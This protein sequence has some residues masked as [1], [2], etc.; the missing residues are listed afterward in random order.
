MVPQVPKEG[1]ICGPCDRPAY[2]KLYKAKNIKENENGQVNVEGNSPLRK[3]SNWHVLYGPG[4]RQA[5]K[6]YRGESCTSHHTTHQVSGTCIIPRHKDLLAP[7]QPST[8]QGVRR[9]HI[10]CLNYR[11][12]WEQPGQLLCLGLSRVPPGGGPV[13]HVHH[14]LPL[15]QVGGDAVVEVLRHSN[16]HQISCSSTG[17]TRY[18]HSMR[19][20]GPIPVRVSASNG[21]L[22]TSRS[23]PTSQR[24][25][26]VSTPNHTNILLSPL[27]PHHLSIQPSLQGGGPVLDDICLPLTAPLPLLPVKASVSEGHVFCN[28]TMQ[29]LSLLLV[30]P[31]C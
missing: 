11:A 26:K 4:R 8:L 12:L 24:P 9:Q 7:L 13:A 18:I 28:Q 30:I 31:P 3:N 6:I 2:L 14:H 21:N 25:P 23:Q 20:Q 17:E 27:P 10:E 19:D 29:S 16:Y 5:S 15:Q 22:I 1:S